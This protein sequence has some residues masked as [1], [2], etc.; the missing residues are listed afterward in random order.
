M[1]KKIANVLMIIVFLPI[2]VYCGYLAF[3]LGWSTVEFFAR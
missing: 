2:S 1:T 3:E